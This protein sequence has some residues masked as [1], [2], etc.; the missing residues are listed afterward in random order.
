MNEKD[1]IDWIS[2]ISESNWKSLFSKKKIGFEKESLRIHNSNISKINHPNSLGSSLTNSYITT[3][4]SEAQLEL[5]TPPLYGASESLS[6]LDDI[7]HYVMKNINDELLWPLSIPPAITSDDDILIAEYGESNEGV[8]KQI[9][10]VGLENRYGKKMQTISGF[11]FNYSLPEEIWSLAKGHRYSQSIEMRSYVYFNILRNIY[12]YNWLLLYLFGAS[13]IFD[14]SFFDKRNKEFIDFDK[15]SVFLPYATSL[16]MSE[17]GYSNSD[18]QSIFI[19]INGLN[20]YISDLL[21]ATKKIEPRYQEFDVKKGEQLNSNVLQI[22][23]EYYAIARAKSIEKD[24]RRQSTSLKNRGVDFIEIRS[25]DLNPFSRVGIDNDT[26]LFF[27]VFM[28]FCLIKPI[29]TLD[30]KT[31]RDMQNNDLSVAK[32]GREKDIFLLIGGDKI[33]LREWG[34]DIFEN[35]IQIAE[36]LDDKNQSHS[37]AIQ[38]LWSTL[39][40]PDETLSARVINHLRSN[41]ISYLE[42]GNTLAEKYKDEYIKKAINQNNLWA[43]LEDEATNSKIRQNEKEIETAESNIAFEG[44]KSDYY[45]R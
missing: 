44:F 31:I 37:K 2:L 14:K 22:E 8:F 40:N 3:D 35:L 7:H 30:K 13:P 5:I 6:A 9:Y 34:K 39:K 19:S 28:I 25:L 23:A 4:F 16:R 32:Y 17:Y 12:K 29:G 1:Y 21:L 41:K 27:E 24:S 11:H 38:S 26:V 15:D 33:L 36:K 43:I 18:R 20:E 45:K 42:F 10:R